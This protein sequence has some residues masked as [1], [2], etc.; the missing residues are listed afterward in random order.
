MDNQFD[1]SIKHYNIREL[2]DIF[3]LPPS[4]DASI[5]EMKETKLRQNIMSD[6]SVDTQI[7]MKTVAILADAKK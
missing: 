3:E 4:Y 5:V 2:E 1:L 6:P 7:K